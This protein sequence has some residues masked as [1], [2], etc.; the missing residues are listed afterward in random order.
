MNLLHKTIREKTFIESLIPQKDPFVMVDKLFHFSEKK[1]ISGFTIP[2]TNLFVD[3]GHFVAAGLIEHMA[4]S[5]AL[6]TGYQYYL[7]NEA[8]PTGYIGA[9]KSATILELPG[10][11]QELITTASI[12]HEI[13]GVTLVAVQVMYKNAVIANSEMKTVLAN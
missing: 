8:A 7:K 9:I 10:M 1:V 6:Y 13:M 3:K 11:G 4:Q 2:S 12:L 5:V